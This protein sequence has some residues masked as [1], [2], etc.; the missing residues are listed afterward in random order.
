[1]RKIVKNVNGQKGNKCLQSGREYDIMKMNTGNGVTF[2]QKLNPREQKVY[3]Y[4]AQTIRERGYAPSVRDIREALGYKSTSTVHMYLGRL[5]MLGYI[6][7]DEGKSRAIRLSD[8][9]PA[10]AGVP[11]LG[12]MPI[13]VS[14]A[15][16]VD[17]GV[18]EQF[19][20]DY[21][22]KAVETI[23]NI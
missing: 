12:K 10:V 1:M 2:M 3:D 13:D 8:S 5:E 21:L 20:G 19:K 17:N 14:L 6:V 18:F 11:L 23:E 16:M 9:T 7:K 15:Q 22:S 4:I